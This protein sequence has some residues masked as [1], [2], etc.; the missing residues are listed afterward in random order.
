M[1]IYND[2]CSTIYIDRYLLLTFLQIVR[3]EGD[4]YRGLPEAC[5]VLL[6]FKDMANAERWTQSSPI[7]KQKDWP[8]PADEL[9]MFAMPLS[10]LPT[11][12]I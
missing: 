3:C 7:F 6:R 12:G 1:I 4:L 11:E 2:M 5:Y 9:E 8:S 10:Y